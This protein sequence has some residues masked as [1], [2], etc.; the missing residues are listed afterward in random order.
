M[1]APVTPPSPSSP[2]SPFSSSS[3]PSPSGGV[4]SVPAEELR[5][6]RSTKW[7]EFPADVLPLWVAEMDVRL[8]PRIRERL[9]GM[10]ESGDTG[11]MDPARLPAAFADF[12]ARRWGLSIDTGRLYI[13][14]DIMRGV[15]ELL[16]YGTAPGDGV[17]INQP[18][19]GP[20]PVTVEEAGRRVVNAPLAHDAATG[21]YEL[22]LDALEDAFRAGNRVWLL[23]N[24]HNPVGRCW[25]RQELSA[26]AEL[27]DRY[28]VLVIADEVHGPLVHAPHTFTPFS[29]LEAESARRAATLFSASKAWNVAGLKCALL[30]T[31]SPRTWGIVEQFCFEVGLGSSILGVAANEAAFGESEEWL[32]GL[33]GALAEN[34]RLLGGL[35]REQVPGV[36]WEPEHAEATY[37]AWLDCRGLGLDDPYATFLQRGRVAFEPGTKYGDAYGGFVRLNYAT[38]P[39]VLR[40]A[41]G[42]MAAA[43]A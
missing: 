43:V 23:C 29:S 13:L 17:V 16:R 31:R 20:F 40:E 24:P 6:R 10:V 21:R 34:R 33:L 41:V 9:S 26:A 4:F 39:E 37:L 19:Y 3:S 8:A 18:V 5:T 27:A 11:Y 2:S 42:R 12:A 14:Q 38:S 36:R 35:L 15:L 28:G 1:A 32:D 22:D 30:T 25:T 7:R